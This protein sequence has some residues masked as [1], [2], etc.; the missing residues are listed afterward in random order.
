MAMPFDMCAP[1]LLYFVLLII[2]LIVAIMHHVSMVTLST[3]ILFGLLWTWLLNTI[4]THGF[5]TVAW[6]LVFLPF[7]VVLFFMLLAIEIIAKVPAAK[8][9][10]AL[11]QKG[12]VPQ[13]QQQPQQPNYG[14][15][16]LPP[17]RQ[18]HS[19]Y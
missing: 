19:G 11:Q 8:A 2:A 1:A 18:Q 12:G 14:N 17:P 15:M 5:K 4:C 3:K 16:P 7:I 13:Q 9:Q 6:I 10:K